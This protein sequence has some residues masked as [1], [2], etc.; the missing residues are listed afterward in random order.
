MYQ[1]NF[2]EIKK[3]VGMGK[4]SGNAEKAVLAVILF[5]VAGNVLGLVRESTLAA[6][7]GASA[8]SDAYKIAF[9]VP[10]ILTSL[11][12]AAI[13]TTFIPVYT[14]FKKNKSGEQVRYFLNNV[15]NSTALVTI[16]VTITGMPFAS[17]F[18]NIIAPGFKPEIFNLAV[19]LTV[20]ML[21]SLIFLALANLTSGF[22]QSNNRFTA[23][24]LTAVPFN[25][26]IIGST[27]LSPDGSV[28]LVAAGSLLGIASQ[29]LVQL[30][31]LMKAGY[32]PKLVLFDCR[33][34]GIKKIFILTMP[35]VIGSIFN[36]LSSIIDKMLASGLGEGSISALDYASRVTGN[37]NNIFIISIITVIYPRL[38]YFSDDIDKFN[39]SVVRTMR[40]IIFTA[41]PAVAGVFVLRI[42]IVRFLYER[43]EF[44]TQDTYITSI[45]LGYLTLCIVSTGIE[46]FL[47]KAFY[48]L[49]DT[50]TPVINGIIGVCI[51][52]VLSLILIR[53]WA[54]AGLA[55]A[56]SVSSM[57]RCC[58]LLIKYK[59]K[60]GLKPG[61][62]IYYLLLKT[63]G[64]SFI[65]GMAVYACSSFYYGYLPGSSSFIGNTVGLMVNMAIGFIIYIVIMYILKIEELGYFIKLINEKFHFSTRI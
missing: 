11:V 17:Y 62:S 30:P 58:M 12:N 23:A 64:A 60:A 63:F 38:A 13:N 6:Y 44:N 45:L 41:L 39:A 61:R 31:S 34:E 22:L 20:I 32:R 56:T 27:L 35:V 21:P 18:I 59:V 10:Y 33:E 25:L 3:L 53:I 9:T 40:I 16:I 26:F 14:E 55:L 37:I 54:I 8:I 57:L 36:H 50:K 29:F 15:F 46:T 5:T 47:I 49:K 1:P 19:K 24:A 48:A 42:P 4:T 43:G 52:I 28:E 2:K 51:N 65:M 7:F